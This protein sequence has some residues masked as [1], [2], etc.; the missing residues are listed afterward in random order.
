MI[1]AYFVPLKE[2]HKGYGGHIMFLQTEYGK[3][4]IFKCN[5]YQKTKPSQSRI[6]FLDMDVDEK[7]IIQWCYAYFKSC[8]KHPAIYRANLETMQQELYMDE[9]IEDFVKDNYDEIV[10]RLN[11]GNK[12]SKS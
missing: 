8:A 11:A 3:T 6:G 9:Y 5:T 2:E 4:L 10:E 7:V 12:S 1:K